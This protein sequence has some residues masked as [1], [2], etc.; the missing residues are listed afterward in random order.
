MKKALFFLT[1]TLFSTLSFG[2][3][4]FLKGQ[5]Q[6]ALTNEP[7]IGATVYTSDL[8]NGTD[9]DEMGRFQL[10]TDSTLQAILVSYVGYETIEIQ[11]KTTQEFV[12]IQLNPSTLNLES[13]VISS[14]DKSLSSVSKIDVNLRPIK[15]SQDVLRSVPGLFIGQHAGGGKAEQIFLRGFD[16]D[17]GTDI[18]ISVDGM[19][20]NMVSH[21][22]GQGYADLHFVIPELIQTVDFG[23]GPYYADQGNF[24][25]A[26]YVNFQT[27][28]VLDRSSVKLEAGQF[29]T[30]RTVALLDILGKKSKEK[31]ENAYLAGEYVASDGPFDSPQNFKRLNVQGKYSLNLDENRFFSLQFSSFGS[32]WDASGQI[33]VRAV[34]SGLIDRF[35]AIDDT[36]G[37]STSR[38]NLTAKFIQTLPNG[39]TLKN[40]LFYSHYEFNLFSNF[41]FFLENPVDGDQIEQKE[42]RN[43]YGYQIDAEKRL[44][45]NDFSLNNRL[46]AGF[47]Y[48]QSNE[49]QLS[50]TKNRREILNRLAYGDVDELNAYVAIDESI[51]LDKLRI[52]AGLRFDYFQFE[53][54]DRLAPSFERL[55]EK[56]AIVSPKLN[57][58]Y[59][60]SPKTQFYLKTGK[61]FHSNDTRVV[62]AQSGTEIL[63]QAYGIDLGINWKPTS[64]LFINAALWTLFL[65]QEFVYVGDAAVVEPS[66]ETFR[67]GIDI[68]ARYQITDWLFADFDYNY[69]LAKSVD[70]PENANRI[71]LAPVSTS[72]GGL[73]FQ[74]KNGFNGSLRYRY[75]ADRPANEDNSVIADGYTI[76]DLNLNYT[77][78]NLEFG[79]AI[80]N[81]LNSEWNEAQFETESRLFDEIEPVSEIHFTPGTP[82][83]LKGRVTYSF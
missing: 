51:D 42:N 67:E 12:Q 79:I 32:R 75:I 36:E 50:Q 2:A 39:A 30:F 71:P 26:G 66:G 11:V 41:T 34:E 21:A 24:N 68:S 56:K 53:Y 54:R 23:K 83:F 46:V 20:V 40:R 58:L 49:N 10:K 33:P 29:N 5:V 1:I 3:H 16:I 76:L 77:L 69:T 47:R 62:V 59:T 74:H 7:L 81:L 17:H 19:P 70:E 57:V 44:D 27:K 9:T 31:G 73:T 61:G 8:K 80:E 35:G 37:G 52:N 64:K 78:P 4:Q 63:P 14:N 15:S 43:L 60:L 6:D 82:F 28:N 25:T 45:F 13:V 38:T 18:A 65:E 72:I 48:D 55:T 22:H